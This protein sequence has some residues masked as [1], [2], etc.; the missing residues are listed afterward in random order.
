M[1]R[2]KKQRPTTKVRTPP[3]SARSGTQIKPHKETT[4]KKP[5]ANTSRTSQIQQKLIFQ[6][7]PPDLHADDTTPFVTPNNPK[8]TINN[9]DD[10]SVQSDITDTPTSLTNHANRAVKIAGIRTTATDVTEGNA[11]ITQIIADPH[12]TPA[13]SNTHHKTLRYRVSISVEASKQPIQEFA[14]NFRKVFRIMQAVAGPNL[15]IAPWDEEQTATFKILKKPA[16]IPDGTNY[17]DR[18]TLAIY[19]GSFLNPKIEGSKVW[20]QLRLSH[21][22]ELKIEISKLGD[23][24]Q[25][26]FHDLDFSVRFPRQPN[27]CQATKSTCL[28]WLYGST[29]TISEEFFIPAIRKALNI[30]DKVALGMQWRAITDK[31]GK[32]PPFDQEKPSPSAIHLDIDHRYASL[33]QRAASD[34]WRQYGKQ[35]Q[36]PQLPNDIQLR[37]VPCFSST[38]CRALSTNAL[39]N[40]TLMKDK[41]HFFVT[42]RIERIEVPFIGLL[43]SPISPTNEITLRRAIMSRAPRSDPTK[44]LIHNVDYGW[45]D[46]HRTYITTVKQYVSEA[47]EFISSLIPEMVFRYGQDCQSWFTAEGLSFFES[48]SWNPDT[49]KTTSLADEDTQNLLDEDL[50]GLG[51]DW[52]VE[53]NKKELPVPIGTSI[54]KNNKNRVTIRNLEDDDDIKSFASAF[55]NHRN[56]PTPTLP[57]DFGHTKVGGTVTL[58]AEIIEALRKPQSAN[59]DTCS[60]STAAKT[61]ESTRLKLSVARN[62]I[63]EQKEAIEQQALELEQ[64]RIEMEYL[65]RS[66]IQKFSPPDTYDQEMIT[67]HPDEEDD[68]DDDDDDDATQKVSP[69]RNLAATFNRAQLPQQTRK[70]NKITI[71]DLQSDEGPSDYAGSSVSDESANFSVHSPP[72]GSNAVAFSDDGVCDA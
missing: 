69:P 34:L 58:S 63:D 23:A 44:R 4:T 43:D 42:E 29:K 31:F 21:V 71:V 59:S 35:K 40:I 36:R 32:R 72:V 10:E 67:F 68:E 30:P 62:T 39:N 17:D 27:H 18:F 1:A 56:Q 46:T 54:L 28:G 61:T 53:N 48:V 51:D 19:T 60:M 37:L 3:K 12:S 57:P 41:Q 50:W 2:G 33:Y 20:T 11:Q 8:T 52:R 6:Q 7:A 5:S 9:N 64:L 55:G 65:K 49:M 16:D 15:W 26:S 66:S 45:Q 13:H 38:Q 25:H 47:H 24:L 70:N 14:K 22:D